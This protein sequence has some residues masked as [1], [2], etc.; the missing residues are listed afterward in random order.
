MGDVAHVLP[1]ATMT[2]SIRESGIRE[3]RAGIRETRV[4]SSRHVSSPR[5]VH[6]VSFF[7][8]ILFVFTGY[9]TYYDN[10]DNNWD[11]GDKGRGAQDASRYVILLFYLFI[12]FSTTY[13]ANDDYINPW[14]NPRKPTNPPCGCGFGGGMSLATPTHTPRT[15]PATHGGFQNP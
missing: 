8:P 1:A 4:G 10:Y 6:F 5:Y 14:K 15:L 7:S 2:T 3:M 9:S 11:Q 12:Y 13:Y